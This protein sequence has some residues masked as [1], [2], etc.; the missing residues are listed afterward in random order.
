MLLKFEGA[1]PDAY[2]YLIYRLSSWH[3]FVVHGS[4]LLVHGGNINGTMPIFDIYQIW[5]VRSVAWLDKINVRGV[6]SLCW[7]HVTWIVGILIYGRGTELFYP[8]R[9]VCSGLLA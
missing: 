8:V 1:K 7:A 2:K 6:R 9:G 4:I 5:L 3:S